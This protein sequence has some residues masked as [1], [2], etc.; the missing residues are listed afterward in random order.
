MMIGHIL[1]VATLP[2]PQKRREISFQSKILNKLPGLRLGSRKNYSMNGRASKEGFLN[3][4]PKH[5]H[6]KL[7]AMTTWKARL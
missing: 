2:L 5:K 6:Q 1:L 4:D 3:M 7:Q